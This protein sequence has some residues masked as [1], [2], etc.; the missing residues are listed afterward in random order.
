MF[1]GMNASDR[2]V[3]LGRLF[4]SLGGGM[5]SLGSVIRARNLQ[6]ETTVKESK[7]CDSQE[8]FNYEDSE[9]SS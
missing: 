4:Q 1:N 2:L 8:D 7:E 3:F 9:K 5:E 6:A